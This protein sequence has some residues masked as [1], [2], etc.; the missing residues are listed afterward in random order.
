MKTLLTVFLSLALVVPLVGCG[1]NR[2]ASSAVPSV[3][4]EVSVAAAPSVSEKALVALPLPQAG[5]TLTLPEGVSTEGWCE[6]ADTSG[7][8]MLPFSLDGAS[9]TLYLRRSDGVDMAIT[10]TEY[11]WELPVGADF[12][13]YGTYCITNAPKRNMCAILWTRDGYAFGLTTSD[14]GDGDLL[15]EIMHTIDASITLDTPYE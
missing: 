13:P 7:I 5:V 15:E 2:P 8:Y 12:D 9:Y 6:V 4:E 11:V 1:I 3:S 14:H 10:G